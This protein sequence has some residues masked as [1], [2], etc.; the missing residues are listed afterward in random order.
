MIGTVLSAAALGQSLLSF[1]ILIARARFH[2]VYLPLA[3]F[4]GANAVSEL[5]SIADHESFQQEPG[6]LV[7]M[8]SSIGMPA[9]L[10]LPPALWLYVRGITTET[11]PKPAWSDVWH[12]IL[13]LMGLLTY[14]FLFLLPDQ[15]WRNLVL[16]SSN[17]PTNLIEFFAAILVSGLMLS[18]IVQIAIYMI[19]ILRRLMRYR[20][21]LRD[22]FASTE[23]R[24][25]HWISW[26]AL[27]AGGYWIAMLSL[28]VLGDDIVP[29]MFE[30]AFAFF[31]IWY[32]SQWGLRQKPGLLHEE[33]ASEEDNHIEKY[34]KSGLT[35]DHMTR[36]A[37]KI[38]AAMDAEPLH[39]NAGMSLRDLSRKIGVVPNYVSQ[40]LNGRIGETFFDYVNRRRINDAL[41]LL[42][43]TNDTIL[44]ITYEV[45]FN[46]RSSFY[47]A[48]KRE[49]GIT[50]SA[51]RA[52]NA[53]A[54]ALVD[55]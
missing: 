26:F 31:L 43:E 55:S 10:T 22:L 44:A 20:A 11:V 33:A 19:V 52:A 18:F 28:A 7:A 23:G 3:V 6:L 32:L 12:Y 41:A 25:L 36:I 54:G 16:D 38:E 49:T 5:S 35:E 1:S 24:E 8:V 47:K 2:Y 48:F 46:S 50:P 37:E 39:R 29:P 40:T 13:P 45:G 21:K 42:I 14:G 4:F 15:G 51:Y 27:L 34:Q 17:G 30:D 9:L 53:P